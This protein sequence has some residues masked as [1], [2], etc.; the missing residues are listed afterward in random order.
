M[1]LDQIGLEGMN[2]CKARLVLI[3]V[4]RPV[5]NQQRFCLDCR[6]WWAWLPLCH[7]PRSGW[8]WFVLAASMSFSLNQTPGTIG[9]LDDDDVEISNLHRQVLHTEQRKGTSKAESAAAA[10]HGY[11]VSTAMVPLSLSLHLSMSLYVSLCVSLCLCTSVSALCHLSLSI[12]FSSVRSFYMSCFRLNSTINTTVHILR[13]LPENAKDIV[14][15]YDIIVDATGLLFFFLAAYTQYMLPTD[16]APTRYLLNDAC[17]A[18]D[19]PLV[20]GSALRWDGQL[21]VYNYQSPSWCPCGWF[22]ACP[23]HLNVLQMGHAIAV[24]SP[25]LPRQRRSPT[26]QTAAWSG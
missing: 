6:V 3:H 18:A 17:L 19:K 24:C 12:L 10:L 21:T 7:V 1:I 14:Q 23:H 25:L 16:N 4:P 20:S 2:V 5:Q 22:S 9:L 15:R 8:S 13:L 11:G 26:A